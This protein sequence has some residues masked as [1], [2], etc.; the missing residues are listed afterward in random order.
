MFCTNCGRSLRPQ[1]RF[2]GY[3]G[4][5]AITSG[6]APSAPIPSASEPAA[7]RSIDNSV[8][9]P[10]L[11]GTSSFHAVPLRNSEP[12]QPDS[13][14]QEPTR[15]SSV[16]SYRARP[17]IDAEP[18]AVADSPAPVEQESLP[19]EISGPPSRSVPDVPESRA[20]APL[21]LPETPVSAYIPPPPEPIRSAFT[22]AAP[23]EGESLPPTAY[24]TEVA[25][26]HTGG[27]ALW[28]AIAVV[29]IGG[30][31]A[32]F[33]MLRPAGSV[34][35]KPTAQSGE[36]SVALSPAL[37]QTT[38][39]NAVD[40]TATVNGTSTPDVTWT[41][42]ENGASGH[43]VPRGILAKG[44][45]MSATAVYVAPSVPGVF[46]VIVASKADPSK[47]AVAEITVSGSSQ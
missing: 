43:V 28:I 47:T 29:L 8:R 24:D 30:L 13:P 20:A 40:L 34:S 3:C 15:A 6:E 35:S 32:I 42:Q 10:P 26:E 1:D 21:V 9:T 39:L 41:V 37:A 36:I 5:P 23:P 38:P 14:G 31:A 18:P 17:N 7:G 11:S 4:T 46:H 22:Y 33:W 44:G 2:C 25:D 12:P 16:F 45:Q 27:R 19:M